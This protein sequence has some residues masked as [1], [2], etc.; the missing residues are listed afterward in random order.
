MHLNQSFRRHICARQISSRSLGASHFL[1]ILLSRV[2]ILPR[3][4]EQYTM[5]FNMR[6]RRSVLLQSYV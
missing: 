4:P 3:K 6:V 1:H 5:D 2:P